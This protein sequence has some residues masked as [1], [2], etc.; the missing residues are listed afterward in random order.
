MAKPFGGGGAPQMGGGIDGTPMPGGASAAAMG[1][2]DNLLKTLLSRG[3]T[4]GMATTMPMPRTPDPSMQPG[5]SG[6]AP[7]AGGVLGGMM[8]GGS[9][10]DKMVSEGRMSQDEANRIKGGLTGRPPGRIE[11]PGL[12]TPPPNPSARVPPAWQRWATSQKMQDAYRNNWSP[13]P[14]MIRLMEGQGSPRGENTP[15]SLGPM[16]GGGNLDPRFQT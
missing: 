7:V 16:T 15:P 13:N 2:G 6:E 8:S 5:L 4:E 10:F 3:G 11:G 12:P 14:M 9:I 1:G